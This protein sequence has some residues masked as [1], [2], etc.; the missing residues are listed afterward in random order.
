M[1][2]IMVF[3]L[4]AK[5]IILLYFM[6][7]GSNY[8]MYRIFRLLFNDTNVR[9]DDQ[10]A[11]SRFLPV[12]VAFNTLYLLCAALSLVPQINNPCNSTRVYRISLPSLTFFQHTYLVCYS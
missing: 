11:D 1:L 6:L 12:N 9:K 10:T 7:L 4:F 8:A 3:D 5:Y 2:L